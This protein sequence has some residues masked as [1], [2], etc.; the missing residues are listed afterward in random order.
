MASPVFSGGPDVCTRNFKRRCELLGIGP[1]ANEPEPKVV[2]RRV[3]S[4][5]LVDGLQLTL[6][7]A[8]Q[9]L[10]TSML[11]LRGPPLGRIAL[12][13]PEPAGKRFRRLESKRRHCNNEQNCKYNKD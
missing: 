6:L 12:G 3:E 11:N 10:L 4:H 2:D 5:E 13:K 9:Y 7:A 1:F 8:E